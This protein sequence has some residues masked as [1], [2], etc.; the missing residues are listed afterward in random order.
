MA[1]GVRGQH[2]TKVMY[3]LTYYEKIPTHFRLSNYV[4]KWTVTKVHKEKAINQRLQKTFALYILSIYDVNKNKFIKFVE[5]HKVIK[6]NIDDTFINH[7]A[8][9]FVNLTC[10][11]VSVISLNSG[12]NTCK[13]SND[14]VWTWEWSNDI[15]GE[16]KVIEICLLILDPLDMLER[17]NWA[18][19][20]CNSC[21]LWW[22]PRAKCHSL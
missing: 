14:R 2:V 6:S 20:Y 18:L 8:K 11:F 15:N 5:K 16:V 1:S 17:L 3:I 19:T 12:T 13:W 9:T 7:F 22:K 21:I 10:I 4:M